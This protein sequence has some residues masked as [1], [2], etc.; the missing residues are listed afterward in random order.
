VERPDRAQ[1]WIQHQSRE[2]CSSQYVLPYQKSNLTKLT[3]AVV[4]NGHWLED[5]KKAGNKPDW[6][7]TAIHIYQTTAE[8][9]KKTVVRIIPFRVL[10]A[11][12]VLCRTTMLA[13]SLTRLFGSPNGLVLIPVSI[14]LAAPTRPRSPSLL[15]TWWT[16]SKLIPTFR[17]MQLSRRDTSCQRHGTLSAMVNSQ[18]LATLTRMRSA[19][20]DCGL[21]GV[22]VC[23]CLYTLQLGRLYNVPRSQTCKR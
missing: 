4:Q 10:S 8:D 2:P 18:Y 22:C 6:D 19:S 3:L 9:A 14:L 16:C 12:D 23:T 7:I 17:A 11:A 15:V 13:S 21:V 1:D 20:T 5:F